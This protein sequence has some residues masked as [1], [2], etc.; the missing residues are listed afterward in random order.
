M[1]FSVDSLIEALLLP[2]LADIYIVVGVA[3]ATAPNCFN[4]A[5]EVAAYGTTRLLRMIYWSEF[6]AGFS[7]LRFVIGVLWLCSE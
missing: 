5:V 4:G 1:A 6:Q 2:Y 3:V 7:L